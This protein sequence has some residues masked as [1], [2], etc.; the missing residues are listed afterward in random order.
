MAAKP[1]IDWAAVE[2]DF[3]TGQFTLRELAAKHGGSHAGIRKRAEKEGWTQDLSAQ[4]RQATRAKLVRETIKADAQD[5]AKVE[6]TVEAA[7]EINKQVILGHRQDIRRT[8]GVAMNLLG[9][10]ERAALMDDQ[11]ELLAEILAGNGAEPADAAKARATVAKAIS[12]TSRIGGVKALAETITKLQA[13]ERTAFGLDEE[14]E[15]GKGTDLDR[16]TDEELDARI[17]EHLA[18]RQG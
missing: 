11:A 12:L 14:G 8:R 1:S 5:P 18:R 9:E 4:V 16:L 7:A 15:K 6:V 3:R 17:N 2:R 13:A 10:L